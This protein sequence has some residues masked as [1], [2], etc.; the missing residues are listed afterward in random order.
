MERELG[1]SLRPLVAAPGEDEERLAAC[2]VTPRGPG[3]PHSPTRSCGRGAVT[4]QSQR[5][6]VPRVPPRRAH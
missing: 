4:V 6:A 3:P 2:L 5:G 1:R